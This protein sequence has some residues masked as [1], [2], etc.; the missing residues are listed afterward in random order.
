MEKFT[1]IEW[2]G[3]VLTEIESRTSLSWFNILNKRLFV[4]TE[5]NINES[6][7]EAVKKAWENYDHTQPKELC[8]VCLWQEEIIDRGTLVMEHLLKGNY[9]GILLLLDIPFAFPKRKRKILE[10]FLAELEKRDIWKRK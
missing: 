10:R 4:D 2:V 9:D 1:K 5:S 7:W 8:Y 3:L 6:R